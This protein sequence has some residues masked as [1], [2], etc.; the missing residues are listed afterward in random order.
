MLHLITAVAF[1]FT[2]LPPS[3]NRPAAVHRVSGAPV[4]TLPT[5]REAA[6]SSFALLNAF[7]LARPAW[8]DGDKGVLLQ[9]K[10]AKPA[11]EGFDATDLPKLTGKVKALML[12]TVTASE[13]PGG[14]VPLEARQGRLQRK[15]ESVLLPLLEVMKEKQKRAELLPALM[16]GH[17]LEL[18]EAVAKLQFA[19]FKDGDRVYKGG[20]V[21]A[22][23]EEIV[24]T[25]EEFIAL[26]KN[27][28]S[29]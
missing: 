11:K 16:K 23:L 24:E 7:V 28:M 18:D 29:M 17:Y 12:Y 14:G 26:A 15:Q 1:G 8:A 22:E 27:S 10:L 25:A 6:L 9:N 4:A 13:K 3:I 2:L 21:E 20:R 19:D 5:R